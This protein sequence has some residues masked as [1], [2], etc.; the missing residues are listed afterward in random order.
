MLMMGIVLMSL[1]FLYKA[2]KLSSEKMELQ[3]A[4][5]SSAYSFSL[6]EARD[7]NFTSYLNRAM[8][9]NEIA[10]AQAVGILSWATY[11]E[12]VGHHLDVFAKYFNA[13]PIVGN[14]I[15]GGITAVASAFKAVTSPIPPVVQKIGNIV[16]KFINGINLGYSWGSTGFHIGSIYLALNTLGEMIER[17]DPDAKLSDAGVL[18]LIMHVATY[19]GIFSKKQKA[20]FTYTHDPA[21]KPEKSGKHNFA[22]MAALVSD[23]RD[24]YSK[25]RSWTLQLPI[26]PRIH[27][28]VVLDL[29]PLGD[30]TV[31]EIDVSFDFFFDRLGGTELRFR[32]GA[33]KGK[34]QGNSLTWSAADVA[35]A[36]IDLHFYLK[37]LIG[38][39]DVNLENNKLYAQACVDLALFEACFPPGN[40]EKFAVPVP[41]S[42]PFATGGAQAYNGGNFINATDQDPE[43]FLITPKGMRDVPSEAYGGSPSARSANSW[44]GLAG[45]FPFALHKNVPN[46]TSRWSL[47]GYKG[48]PRYTDTNTTITNGKVDKPGEYEGYAAPYI[49]V[50]VVKD[51]ANIPDSIRPSGSLALERKLADGEMGAIAKGELY[52][53]R[54]NDSLASYF[55]R[56]DGATEYD[57]AFNPYWQA[58][59]TDTNHIDRMGMLLIQQKQWWLANLAEPAF[60]IGNNVLNLLNFF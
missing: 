1:T 16:V 55:R 60:N 59:L 40:P 37:V 4:A 35:Q 38:S 8:V 30:V 56:A 12:S 32:K 43:T 21:K 27:E 51:S 57:N 5:D 3:N 52:F 36:A 47:K 42:M 54:P 53:F 33:K 13:A 29:G 2:G 41:T 19:H 48:L 49:M 7:L 15:S 9:A 24:R 23:A 14:A 58:R 34:V 20:A 25:S 50:G 28:S 10:I 22:T 17:N 39:V 11:L 26:I 6:I 18:S 45:V 44:M 31:F 46:N